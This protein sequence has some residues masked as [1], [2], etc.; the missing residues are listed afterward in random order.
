VLEYD[1]LP[2]PVHLFI[3]KR[4]NS[5]ISLLKTRAN[6][7]LP[8]HLNRSQRQSELDKLLEWAVGHIEKKGLYPAEQLERDY[9]GIEEIRIAGEV[10]RLGFSADGAGKQLRCKTDRSTRRI[11]ITGDRHNRPKQEFSA[12]IRKLVIGTFNRHYLGFIQNLVSSIN[13]NTFNFQ[14]QT[15]RL[16]YMKSRWGSCSAKK[17]INLSLRLLLLPEKIRDYVIIHELAHLEEMNHSKAFW[18]LVEQHVPEYKD[19]EKWLK[20]NGHLFDL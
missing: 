8:D 18:Q 6:V 9:S 20:D 19:H 15:V 5:R 4:R 2:V 16:K 14:Y 13:D 1:F 3:E 11:C 17:N 10:W 12:A 7:R